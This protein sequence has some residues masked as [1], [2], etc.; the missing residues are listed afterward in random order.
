LVARP[1]SHVADSE[2]IWLALYRIG[3]KMST[4]FRRH[5]QNLL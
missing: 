1:A 2:L 4:K 3:K 5:S